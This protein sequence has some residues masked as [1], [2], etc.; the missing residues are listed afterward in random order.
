MTIDN[1]S[2]PVPEWYDSENRIYKDRLIE[3]FNA[4]EAKLIEL[5]KLDAFRVDPPDFSTIVIPD[6]T[7]S[8]PDNSVVNLKSFLN[9]TGTVGYPIACEFDGTT[10]KRV[11]L[12]TF[13]DYQYIVKTNVATE[14]S[15]SKPYVFIDYGT[16]N[17]T[18]LASPDRPENSRLIGVFCDNKVIGLYDNIYLGINILELLAKMS[19]SVSSF[20]PSG[21]VNGSAS[22]MQGNKGRVVGWVVRETGAWSNPITLRDVGG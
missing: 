14:A 12:W 2:L 13:P 18:A 5:S 20:D 9:I 16:G 22:N 4:I 19:Q 1:F 7:L 15:T 11:A 3:N 8:S 6:T 10:C 21:V 17:I